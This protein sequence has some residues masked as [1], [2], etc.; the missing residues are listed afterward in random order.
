MDRLIE[1]YEKALTAEF[2]LREGVDCFR[3]LIAT[4]EAEVWFDTFADEPKLAQWKAQ[5]IVHLTLEGTPRYQ[6]GKRNLK[7][8]KQHHGLAKIRLAVVTER[9]KLTRARLY[10]GRNEMLDL[11][12][13]ETTPDND[14]A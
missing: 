2:A 3:E 12:E 9:L 7:D 14:L 4:V 11:Q 10:G 13:V 5:H 6:D 1:D 8:A